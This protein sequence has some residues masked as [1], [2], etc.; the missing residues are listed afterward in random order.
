MR[1]MQTDRNIL[2]IEDI[3]GIYQRRNEFY[4]FI[5]INRQNRGGLNERNSPKRLYFSSKV[6]ARMKHLFKDLDAYKLFQE[7]RIYCCCT[8]LW[9]LIINAWRSCRCRDNV[10]LIQKTRVDL[11]EGK[12]TCSIINYSVYKNQMNTLYKNALHMFYHYL[13]QLMRDKK[14]DVKVIYLVSQILYKD[15]PLIDIFDLELKFN[16]L[17]TL[18]NGTR[19][20]NVI[21]R[22]FFCN[23][24]FLK[25]ILTTILFDYPR[26]INF[27]FPL[28]VHRDT[29]KEF[30]FWKDR[31]GSSDKYLSEFMNIF[32]KDQTG[33][34]ISEYDEA[35]PDKLFFW[36]QF[37]KFYSKTKLVSKKRKYGLLLDRAIFNFIKDKGLHKKIKNSECWLEHDVDVQKQIK[38]VQDCIWDEY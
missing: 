12:C 1:C 15:F 9:D 18:C 16:E 30:P 19:S 22:N 34:T 33:L 6:E 21:V 32:F 3:T 11:L 14:N 37:N 17:I 23:V 26:P 10:T 20:N 36:N 24:D 31:H 38:I 7:K 28:V 5:I 8:N 2:D 13:I 4:Q 29:P 35:N 25:F 27:T